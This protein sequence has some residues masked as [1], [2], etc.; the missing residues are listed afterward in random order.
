MSLSAQ[1]L[2]ALQELMAQNKEL[3]A[4]VQATDDAAQAAAII[5]DAAA[6]NGIEAIE[7]DLAKYFEEASKAASDQALSDQQLEAVAGGLNDDGR[8]A[9]LSVFT[10]GIG[11][12]LISIGQSAGG[13]HADGTARYLD[14][15]F[16]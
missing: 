15:K 5:A 13:K 6:K 16:C 4:Q 12:A 14:K 9:L 8:M 7:S 11:C 3:L 1:T 2:S 10:L